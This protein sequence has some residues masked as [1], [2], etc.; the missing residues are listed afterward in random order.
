ME[1]QQQAKKRCRVED[2]L[3]EEAAQT[4][5]SK[6]NTRLELERI[7]NKKELGISG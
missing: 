3:A 7:R 5:K 4:K 6:S 2:F 1:Q